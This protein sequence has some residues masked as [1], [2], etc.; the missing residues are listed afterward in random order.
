MV[1]DLFSL[2]RIQQALEICKG[3]ANSACCA[4]Y[5]NDEEHEQGEKSE[6][7]IDKR[8][9]YACRQ[10]A[11]ETKKHHHVFHPPLNHKKA[12]ADEFLA[13]RKSRP[14]WLIRGVVGRVN[15]NWRTYLCGSG[16]PA[17]V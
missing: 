13:K 15:W 17:N 10:H 5:E 2:F 6:D 16:C 4:R 3:I 14:S 1:I 12:S 9:K 8:E 11:K 7:A